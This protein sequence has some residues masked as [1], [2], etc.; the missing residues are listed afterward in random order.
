MTKPI[1]PPRAYV[2]EIDGR[3]VV[4]YTADSGRQA[5]ELLHEAWFR[6]DLIELRSDGAPVWDGKAKLRVRPASD[7]EAAEFAA[8]SSV[9]AKQQGNGEGD[10]VLVFLIPIDQ[11]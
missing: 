1:L 4:A 6:D 10:S 8:G 3:P 2:V 5:R 9:A 11:D 7:A